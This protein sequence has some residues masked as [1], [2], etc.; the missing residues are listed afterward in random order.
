MD[1]GSGIRFPANSRSY[2]KPLSM[3]ALLFALSF[4]LL[5][6]RS[7]AQ[8][9]GLKEQALES[10]RRE[11]YDE[12]VALM[13]RAAEADPTDAE[14][15]YYL[16]FFNHY[17]AYDSRPLK[18]YDLSYSERVFSY[19]YRALE[20]DPS[21]GDARYFY[22]AECSA[23]A[24]HAMRE[25]D[26]ER[27]RHFYEK[28]FLK[29]AYPPWL[30]ELGRNMLDGCDRDAILFAGGNGDF[31]VC[32]Y[33]QLHEGYRRDVSVLPVGYTDR[34]W[35][36]GYL[37]D[38]LE[39][40]QRPLAL[41]LSDEQILEMRPFKWDTPRTSLSPQ[42][43]VMLQLV[44]DNYASR[45]IFFSRMGNPFF[46]AGLDSF[47]SHGGLVSRLLPFPTAGTAHET[48]VPRLERLLRADRLKEVR[49]VAT[50]DIPRISGC[51]FV[52]TEALARLA[53]YYRKAGRKEDLRALAGL[54]RRYLMPVLSSGREDALLEELEQASGS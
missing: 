19:L 43:A 9:R 42:P 22:G 17:R 37:R 10:F 3:K 4:F 25:R 33:L 44:E 34:P 48:D 32:S 13:E 7:P 36:A 2:A 51:L 15:W 29:G 16:G 21:L 24:F 23:N 47:F 8:V 50:T 1:G 18:G 6:F 5:A 30:L 14:S 40:A 28:A 12:A 52:Y 53:A 39:G 31:D 38:G 35:Y 41:S 46:F 20:L 26:L 11:R 45:P 27:L 49:S 54:Y